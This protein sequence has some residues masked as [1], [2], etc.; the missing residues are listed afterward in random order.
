VKFK[1]LGYENQCPWGDKTISVV[2]WFLAFN[3]IG[4]CS[5][6]YTRYRRTRHAWLRCAIARKR[7]RIFASEICARIRYL[8]EYLQFIP[9]DP[10]LASGCTE[11][12]PIEANSFR[13]RKR[14][15]KHIKTRVRDMKN[16]ISKRLRKACRDSADRDFFANYKKNHKFT[17]I[18]DA[19]C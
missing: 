13:A 15:A 7:A 17:V 2:G 14:I 10:G 3:N 6:G 12:A 16:P 19:F 11:A 8:N 5:R 9:I 1:P 18:R 4:R